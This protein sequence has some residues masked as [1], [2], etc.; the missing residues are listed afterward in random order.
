VVARARRGRK[1]GDLPPADLGTKPTDHHLEGGALV[2]E[3]GGDLGGGA[4]VDEDRTQRLVAAVKG[5][6]GLEEEA[7]AGLSI[8]HGGSPQLTV[9]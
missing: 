2:T 4:M 8:P 3:L 1:G 9:F 6:V 5:Q 7:K